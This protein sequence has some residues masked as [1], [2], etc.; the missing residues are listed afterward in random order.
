MTTQPPHVEDELARLET[1]WHEAL[2][3][4]TRADVGRARGLLASR[5]LAAEAVEEYA[6]ARHAHR[7]LV[8][9]AQH[10]TGLL[11]ELVKRIEELQAEWEG[12]RRY[13]ETGIEDLREQLADLFELD[14]AEGRRRWLREV[15]KA[16]EMAEGHAAAQIAAFELPLEGEPRTA[17]SEL[18][19]AVR[20]WNDGDLDAGLSLTDAVADGTL[21]ERLGV[22]DVRIRGRAHR[23]AAWL[24]FVIFDDPEAASAELDIAIRLL[25]TSG[26]VRAERA[27]L[28]LRMEEVE[29]ATNDAHRAVEARP[30]GATGHLVLGACAEHG[31]DLVAAAKLYRTGLLQMSPYELSTAYRRVSLLEPTGRMLL[32]MGERL[33][34]LDRPESALRVLDEALRRFIVDARPY[35]HVDAH[36]HRSIALE[37]MGRVPEAARA[38][39]EAGKRQYWHDELGD[40]ADQL[41]RALDLDESLSEAGWYLAQAL[42]SLSDSD[43]RGVPDRDVVDRAYRVWEGNRERFGWPAG[44]DSWAFLTRAAIAAAISYGR[45]DAAWEA[46]FYAERAIVHELVDVTFADG[47]RWVLAARYLSE[48]ELDELAL[49]CSDRADALGTATFPALVQRMALLAKVG[50]INE[51][52][53]VAARIESAH[54]E[55]EWVAHVRGW[56]AFQDSRFEAALELLAGAPEEDDVETVQ[57]FYGLSAL[58]HLG[59]GDRERALEAYSAML[60]RDEDGADQ[61]ELAIAHAALGDVAAARERIRRAD[62]DPRTDLINRESAGSFIETV[63]GNIDEAIARLGAAIDR[64]ATVRELEDVWREVDLRL[65]L[66]PRPQLRTAAR[67]ALQEALAQANDA[68]RRELERHAP[69]PGSRLDETLSRYAAS[70]PDGIPHCVLRAG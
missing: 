70:A 16:I 41:A 60:Q 56:A 1:M 22:D 55:T 14:P 58:C 51:V 20:D 7:R 54:G 30:T 62:A 3:R 19:Q 28:L 9:H 12:E 26:R 65:E 29:R 18:A 67:H 64:T 42:I 66:L 39:L 48:V 10:V 53:R 4:V 35:G 46:L 49:E 24:R 34:E 25:P 69:T 47:D 31:N 52:E 23:I 5:L 32:R 44:R 17:G 11:T 59:L 40:A 45:E 2:D 50:R 21:G 43:G 13:S 61:C 37:R 63:A 57:W 38:A 8:R 36:R 27:A 6:A 15:M 68:R 33:L